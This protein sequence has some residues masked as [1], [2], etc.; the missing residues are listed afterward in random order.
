MAETKAT[1][2]EPPEDGA[3]ALETLRG[4]Y[5]EL[6]GQRLPRAAKEGRDWPIR[7]DHCFARVILDH[8]FQGQWYDHIDRRK[9]AAYRQLRADQLE[10]AIDLGRQILE[11]PDDV[12]GHMNAQSLRWRGKL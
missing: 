12:L 5:M 7:F 4:E 10:R 2:G 1:P 3:A 9:G 11:G 8:L 6:V